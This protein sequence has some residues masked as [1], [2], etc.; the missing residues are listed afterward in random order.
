VATGC[1]ELQ[2]GGQDAGIGDVDL[3]VHFSRL[4]TLKGDG[5]DVRDSH[6]DLKNPAPKPDWHLWQCPS[7]AALRRSTSCRRSQGT[8]ARGAALPVATNRQEFQVG[9]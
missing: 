7:I 1:G 5:I 9:I 3:H 8:P 6:D 2:P 4:D